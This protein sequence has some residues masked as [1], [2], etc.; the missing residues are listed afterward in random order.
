MF[1]LTVSQYTCWQGDQGAK[2]AAYEAKW[3]SLVTMSGPV[4][5]GDVPWLPENECGAQNLILYGVQSAAERKKRLRLE[6]MRWHPDKFVAK[7]ASRVI[8][9]DKERVAEGVKRVSQ[10]LNSL[11]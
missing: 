5:H 4:L 7:F 8:A 3:Q 6:L 9:K 1:T 2:R 11:G 10:M